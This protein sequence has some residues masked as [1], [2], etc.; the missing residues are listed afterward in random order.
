MVTCNGQEG[1]SDAGGGVIASER[2]AADVTWNISPAPSQSAPVMRGA[3]TY[4]KPD[5][6]KNVWVAYASELRIRMTAPIT[7][8]RGRM[9]VMPRSVSRLTFCGGIGYFAPSLG[10]TTTI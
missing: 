10:P 5:D 6:W 3:W 2:A 4:M 7:P 9:W 8:V 1:R